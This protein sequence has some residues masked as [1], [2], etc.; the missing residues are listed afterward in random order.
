M[1]EHTFGSVK[2]R[3]R[4]RKNGSGFRI[5]E[6]RLLYLSPSIFERLISFLGPERPRV[7]ALIAFELVGHP[8]QRAKN[9]GTVIAGQINDTGL[10]DEAAEFDQ[11]PRALAT[12]DLPCAHVMPCP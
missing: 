10:Y 12:L 2:S 3:H 1:G 6:A 5:E 4:A 11:M 8:E 7:F 9:E